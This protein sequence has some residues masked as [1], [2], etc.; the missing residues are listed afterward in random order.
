MVTKKRKIALSSDSGSSK[1]QK[2]IQSNTKSKPVVIKFSC[3]K[4]KNSFSGTTNCVVSSSSKKLPMKLLENVKVLQENNVPEVIEVEENNTRIVENES[5]LESHKVEKFDTLDKKKDRKVNTKKLDTKFSCDYCDQN[6]SSIMKLQ[7]HHKEAHKVTL[8]EKIDTNIDKRLDKK[9]YESAKPYL[10]AHCTHCANSY[11]S[12]S[13]I[14]NHI[15]LIHEFDTKTSARLS[16]SY[17]SYITWENKEPTINVFCNLCKSK[18][19]AVSNI[20]NW[21]PI[22]HWQHCPKQFACEE[23]GIIAENNIGKNV[24]TKPNIIDFD[25]DISVVE[26]LKDATSSCDQASN[27]S[28]SKEN[29][30]TLEEIMY[31]D[32]PEIELE[33]IEP[34][35][36]YSELIA[37]ALQNSP[38][39]VLTFLE[40]CIYIAA[41][42]P[43][44]KIR[45]SG[46]KNSLKWKLTHD[47]SFAKTSEAKGSSWTLP[48]NPP[49]PPDTVDKASDSSYSKENEKQLEEIMYPDLLEY[50]SADL[51]VDKNIEENFDQDI[52]DITVVEDFKIEADD[53]LISSEGANVLVEKDFEENVQENCHPNEE[54]SDKDIKVM[55][56]SLGKLSKV[57]V[58]EFKVEPMNHEQAS[59]SLQS[60]ENKTLDEK[61]DTFDKGAE[62]NATEVNFVTWVKE[63]NF[64]KSVNKILHE[65]VTKD[66]EVIWVLPKDSLTKEVNN[67]ISFSENTDSDEMAISK[68][69][70]NYSEAHCTHCEVRYTRSL[71]TLK[72]LNEGNFSGA[73]FTRRHVIKDKHGFDLNTAENLSGFYSSQTTL[74]SK[75]KVVVDIMCNHCGSKLN[76]NDYKNHWSLCQKKKHNLEGF[77]EKQALI[78]HMK[79]V[80][81]KKKY[82]YEAHCTHCEISYD[83]KDDLADHIKHKHGFDQKDAEK[84]SRFYAA[85]ITDDDIGTIIDI[86]CNYCESKL[87]TFSTNND[88][89]S[90]PKNHWIHCPKKNFINSSANNYANRPNQNKICHIKDMLLKYS[91]NPRADNVELCQF[92]LELLI[93]KEHN[94]IIHWVGKECEFKL[95]S[96]EEVAQLWGKRKNKPKMNYHNLTRALRYYHDGE[97]LNTVQGQKFTY[98]F[99]CN[100]EEFNGNNAMNE[101]Y[102][103]PD[104]IKK[105]DVHEIHNEAWHE[106]DNVE[107]FDESF[108]NDPEIVDC[109]IINVTFSKHATQTTQVENFNALLTSKEY[110]NESHDIKGLSEKGLSKVPKYLTEPIKPR[111]TYS[112]LI[113]EALQNSSSGMLTLSDIFVSVSARY[114]YYKIGDPIW[115]KSLRG[116][117]IRQDKKSDKSFTKVSVDKDTYWTFSKMHLDFTEKKLLPKPIDIDTEKHIDKSVSKSDNKNTKP[118]VEP[119]SLCTT[120]VSFENEKQGN[121]TVLQY[122][123]HIASIQEKLENSYKCNYCNNYYSSN[124]SLKEHQIRCSTK[125]IT[126]SEKKVAEPIKQTNKTYVKGDCKVPREKDLSEVPKIKFEAIKPKMSYS[127]LIAEA[128]QNSPSGMLPLPDIFISISAKHP[129]YKMTK[130]QN[131]KDS[132][133][134]TL[135][136]QYKRSDRRFTQ[137]GDDSYPSSYGMHARKDSF[138]TF[139]KNSKVDFTAKEIPKH[140]DINTETKSDK[141]VEKSDTKSNKPNVKLSSLCTAHVS[142]ENGKTV[143]NFSCNQCGLKLDAVSKIRSHYDLFHNKEVGKDVDK[144]V[145]F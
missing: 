29:T 1:R 68:D 7:S 67:V 70:E 73:V 88:T 143:R 122:E 8:F 64:D 113:A 56:S 50:A 49:K 58:E 42:Y 19:A 61:I 76:E 101:T 37:E 117:L 98:K 106:V 77:D 103:E 124:S 139:S 23:I 30:K 100:L 62:K 107:K 66:N 69:T 31:P 44:Y 2:T 45:Q 4:P 22:G 87:D 53:V 94:K 145:Q 109:E 84:L 38:N 142:F 82:Y 59:S 17:S 60:K 27:S 123:K 33:P 79:S 135:T 13:E 115:K 5:N 24:D 112:E 99:V 121:F 15:K 28:N 25:E 18:L 35:M 47:K 3:H 136:E 132:L 137:V 83:S 55:G 34:I 111:M 36:S 130:L 102:K 96:P 46:W 114:P 118:N 57:E 125:G 80:H 95:E 39:G 75:G 116:T 10:E 89:I 52:E 26:D 133:R 65:N 120:H 119:S 71:A 48:K 14:R 72:T 93:D 78:Q 20:K 126:S 108:G 129:Y 144:N 138:W 86:I 43:Y 97:I 9:S 131:W 21:R 81:E 85:Q 141:S 41:K 54:T 127:E 32:L 11:T 92:L 140:I 134:K 74:Y 51:L 16:E 90:A 104:M 110:E 63:M 12:Q 6:F 105:S 40:I 128:L 91:E